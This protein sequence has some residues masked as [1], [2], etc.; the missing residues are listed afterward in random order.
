MPKRKKLTKTQL[1]IKNI[2]SYINKIGQFFGKNSP[3]Y[4]NITNI[5]ADFETYENKKE[6]VNIQNTP[7]N[8][9]QHQ[10]IR[11][12]QHNKKSFSKLVKEFEKEVADY[13]N[14]L[15]D[16]EKAYTDTRTFTEWFKKWRT[17]WNEEEQYEVSKLAEELSVPFN[18]ENWYQDYEYRR[19]IR[20]DLFDA[21]KDKIRKEAFERRE[22]AAGD[23]VN[24]ASGETY[25]YTNED[26]RRGFNTDFG[27]AY[28]DDGELK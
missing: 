11:S 14:D 7:E 16:A 10:K 5:I 1:N 27:Y 21:I 6:Y 15:S 2:N 23:T 25:T 26:L 3:E 19:Q 18:C 20:R 28:D 12:I 17:T 24:T 9:K 4:Q 13:Y 22:N 8:R